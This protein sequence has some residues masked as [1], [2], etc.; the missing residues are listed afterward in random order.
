MRIISS[1]RSRL[2]TLYASSLTPAEMRNRK[3]ELFA[4]LVAELRALAA[5]HGVKSRLAEELAVSPSN[6]RLA[7]LATYYECVP[8]FQRMLAR[9]QHDLPKFYAAVNDLAKLPK[10]ERH[11][12]VCADPQ[13]P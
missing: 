10:S 8:G 1:Y 11:A 2:A 5:S 13:V 9:E 6:A 12:Q 7:S 3:A 4:G